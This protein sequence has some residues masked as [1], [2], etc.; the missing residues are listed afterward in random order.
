VPPLLWLVSEEAGELSGARFGRK[1]LGFLSAAGGGGQRGVHRGRLYC[2]RIV[3]C[4]V[5]VQTGQPCY[6]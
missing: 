6:H 5:R 3:I 4:N 2:P 1:V